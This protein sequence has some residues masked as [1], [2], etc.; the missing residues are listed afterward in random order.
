MNTL[1]QK[2]PVR[3][4]FL[5]SKKLSAAQAKE[6]AQYI[7]FAPVI[8][9]TALALRNLGILP[10]IEAACETGITLK[11]IAENLP[12]NDYGLKVLIDGGVQGGLIHER[13]GRYV[14]SNTGYFFLNDEMT[15]VNFDFVNDICYRAL[16]HLESSVMNGQPE[17]LKEFGNWPTIYEGLSLLP[18]QARKSWFAFDHFYSDDAFDKVLPIV[19]KNGAVNVLDIGGNTGKFAIQC[20]NYD[21]DSTVTI[22]DLPGQLNLARKNIRGNSH[23]E[24]INFFEADM[25]DEISKLP[26]GANVIWMS[27]FL[28][29]F[30]E[31]EIVSILR[32][33]VQ[34]MDHT[35]RV[36]IL[37]PLTNRQRFPAASFVV[38][39]TSLY[40]TTVANGNS[41]MYSFDDMEKLINE[42]GLK[43][44]DTHTGLGICQSL[45]IC[46]KAE[47]E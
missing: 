40:F 7:A 26:A 36:Y 38:Q 18:D 39:L 19:F 6:K 9:K 45:I 44:V 8:F 25:L 29:C 14:L 13:D 31:K 37:E 5:D 1:S 27:Q 15:R 12:V 21:S 10:L 23:A 22:V 35:A 11:E 33:C 46:S 20:V 2:K 28:D 30:S 32:K 42:A 3:N 24:R 47:Q 4:S 43:I 17:G 34:I 41:R 16:D